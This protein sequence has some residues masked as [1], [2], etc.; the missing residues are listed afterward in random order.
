MAKNLWQI[1]EYNYSGHYV[2]FVMWRLKSEMTIPDYK[3]TKYHIQP[4]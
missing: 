2:G 1:T 4:N 3:V